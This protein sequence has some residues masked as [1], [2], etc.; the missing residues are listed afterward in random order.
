MIQASII[1]SAQNSWENFQSNRRHRYEVSDD[2]TI[3]AE[4]G[5]KSIIISVVIPK[6]IL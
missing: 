2:F 5:S 1:I 3:G 6:Y 4:T